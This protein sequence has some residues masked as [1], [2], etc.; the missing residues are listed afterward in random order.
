MKKVTS[1]LFAGFFA[2]A[3]I[4]CGGEKKKADDKKGGDTTKT[5]APA[6]EPTP[7]PTPEPVDTTAAPADAAVE[8][9]K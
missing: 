8:T 6:P 1:I 4:A 3:L 2:V 7:E 5:E 9:T